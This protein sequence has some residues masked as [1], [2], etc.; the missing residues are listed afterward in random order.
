[1]AFLKFDRVLFNFSTSGILG[2][3]AIFGFQVNIA[4]VVDKGFLQL[5]YV[6]IKLHCFWSRVQK[7][8]PISWFLVYYG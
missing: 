8:P 2:L 4:S 3:F 5:I 6:F 7:I 1:M